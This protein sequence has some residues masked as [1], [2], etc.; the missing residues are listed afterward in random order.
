MFRRVRMWTISY[1][2]CG[3]SVLEKYIYVHLVK[4]TTLIYVDH[5]RS[6]H[7]NLFAIGA[8]H[9]KFKPAVLGLYPSP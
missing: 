5:S 9:Q 3:S 8:T 6:I 1:R 4:M 7:C 2:V